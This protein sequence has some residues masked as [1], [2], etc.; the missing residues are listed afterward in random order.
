MFNC[1]LASSSFKNQIL[2]S[3]LEQNN[4]Q[5]RF[6][7][8]VSHFSNRQLLLLNMKIS[9]FIRVNLIRIISSVSTNKRLVACFNFDFFSVSLPDKCVNDQSVGGKN[10]SNFIHFIDS[11]GYTFY[12]TQ[13]LLCD[14]LS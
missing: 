14:S 2:L 12:A 9:V 1:S 8:V 4:L 3:F 6:F 11:F 5:T 10:K 7:F 13:N